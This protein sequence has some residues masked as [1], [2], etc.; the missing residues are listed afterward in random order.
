MKTKQTRKWFNTPLPMARPPAFVRYGDYEYRVKNS[1]SP[2]EVRVPGGK[3]K[4]LE[5]TMKT[6]KKKFPIKNITLNQLFKTLDRI[7]SIHAH[8]AAEMMGMDLLEEKRLGN[9]YHF[10]NLDVYEFSFRRIVVEFS[11]LGC[12]IN[13]RGKSLPKKDEEA[14]LDSI[15]KHLVEIFGVESV[16]RRYEDDDAMAQIYIFEIETGMDP[17]GNFKYKR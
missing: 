16:S 13:T 3:W 2:V 12:Q 11:L 9:S 1:N 7:K 5:P 6:K 17:W 10:V 14:L 8:K 4:I 15:L